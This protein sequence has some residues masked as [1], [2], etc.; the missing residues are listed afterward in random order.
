MRAGQGGAP[1]CI[2]V[3]KRRLARRGGDRV[4]LRVLANATSCPGPV[5]RLRPSQVICRL[6]LAAALVWLFCVRLLSCV[7]LWHTKCACQ[8][9]IGDALWAYS[10]AQLA[11]P[12]SQRLRTHGPAVFFGFASVVCRWAAFAFSLCELNVSGGCAILSAARN[13]RPA[14]AR[15]RCASHW[16]LVATFTFV[17]F[18]RSFLR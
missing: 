12:I 11:L 7:S 5:P 9:E 18:V 1:A 16:N 17:C 13:P 15:A 14:G 8:L 2:C 4:A 3:A 10:A 6:A